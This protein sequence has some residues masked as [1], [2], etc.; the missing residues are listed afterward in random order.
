MKKKA[1]SVAGIDVSKKTFDVAV[2]D[3]SQ[4]AS[5]N[6]ACFANNEKGY[7]KLDGWLQEMELT[8]VDV[9][10]C[11]ENTGLYH[12]LLANFLIGKG[13]LVWVETPVEIKWSMGIQRGK[14]D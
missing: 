4:D 2:G 1:K 9:L 7:S 3:N 14:S 8:F 10:F 5:I 11:M 6:K 13:A 12:R